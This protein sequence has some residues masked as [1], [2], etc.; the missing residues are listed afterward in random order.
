[1]FAIR[2]VVIFLLLVFSFSS[3][4]YGPTLY[5]LEVIF[6]ITLAVTLMIQNSLNYI[7]MHV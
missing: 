6:T 1:M 7:F 3:L 2:V 4:K 5:I